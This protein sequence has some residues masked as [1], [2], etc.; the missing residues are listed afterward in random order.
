MPI[1]PLSLNAKLIFTT[2][3]LMIVWAVEKWLAY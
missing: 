2:I 3:A 1:D